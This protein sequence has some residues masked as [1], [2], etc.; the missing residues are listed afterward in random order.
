MTTLEILRNNRENAQ[1][2]VNFAALK[3]EFAKVA[4]KHFAPYRL[5]QLAHIFE[6][7]TADELQKEVDAFNADTK[8]GTLL[9]I[10][11]A[12][13]TKLVGNKIVDEDNKTLF[14]GA[15]CF[16]TIESTNK[17]GEVIRTKQLYS[18]PFVPMTANDNDRIINY[19]VDYRATIA[20]S[21]AAIKIAEKEK[22][23]KE[24]TELS[25]QI[26]AAAINGDMAKVAE[27]AAK[28]NELKKQL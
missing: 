18:V 14:E 12:S 6:G 11:V 24:I 16:A 2:K 5:A 21:F 28:V 22:I 8:N 17:E 27:L 9:I 7:A 13:G 20:D 15:S 1:E 19:W 25:A 10:S 26:A 4:S 3:K 23:N